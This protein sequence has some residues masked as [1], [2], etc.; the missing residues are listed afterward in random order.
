MSKKIGV[1]LS[2][3][4][5]F[6]GSEIHEVVL[7]LLYLDQL[8]ATVQCIAPDIEQ[9]HVINHLAGEETAEK[10][11][12]L[13]ESARIAR[14]QVLPLSEAKMDAYDGLI[15]PGGFGAAKNL[16]SFAFDGVDCSVNPQL[17]D[18]IRAAHSAGKPMGFLCISPVICAK[19]LGACGV[20]LTIGGDAEVASAIEQM[21]ARHVNREVGEIEADEANKIVSSPAYMCGESIGEVSVGIARLVEKVV[22]LA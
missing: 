11:R 1:I 12:V 8:G 16:C 2:G 10:R 18:L 21:G 4:G 15:F 19:V 6:D 17:V 20:A 3:C 7:T 22:E 13:V 5:V 9:H 14:G